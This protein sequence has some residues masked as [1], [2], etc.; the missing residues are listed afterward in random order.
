MADILGKKNILL[1]KG[2]SSFYTAK[3]ERNVRY[4]S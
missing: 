1:K 4:L 3:N 2:N